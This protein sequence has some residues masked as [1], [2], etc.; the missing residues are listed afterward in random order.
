MH[1]KYACYHNLFSE[2]SERA[3]YIAGVIAADGCVFVGK[4]NSNKNYLH[5]G[6]V[7][8]LSSKDEDFLGLLKETMECANPIGKYKTTGINGNQYESV[9][10]SITSEQMVNDLSKFNI[11]PK[12]TL[13]YDMPKWLIAH[14]L[15]NHFLR[16]YVDGDGSFY[17]C[18][19][20]THASITFSLRGTIPFLTNVKAVL[21]T[22]C[23]FVTTCKPTTSN[24]IGKFTL[25]SNTIIQK[26]TNYLYK[27]AYIFLPRKRDIARKAEQ[28]LLV[29]QR[30]HD[31]IEQILGRTCSTNIHTNNTRAAIIPR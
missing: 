17:I 13:I 21:E 27:D 10:L 22:Q 7:I 12:K 24:G 15:L 1:C 8:C 16:G 29:K 28:I 6:L 4:R 3:F 26:V 5:Y 23:E 20:T 9:K 25:H 2:G 30:A 11:V 19:D 18:S 31:E 14:P